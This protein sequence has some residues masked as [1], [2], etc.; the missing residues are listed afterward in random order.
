MLISGALVTVASDGSASYDPNGAFEALAVGDMTTDTFTYQIDDGN[1]GTD[2][3][4]VSVVINGVN[5][6][7]DAV[8]DDFGVAVDATLS[9]NVLDNNGNGED[10]DVDASD[11]LAVTQL[12]GSSAALGVATTITSGA[13]VTLNADG[14]FTYD[15]NGAFSGLGVGVTAT[16]TF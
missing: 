12:N 5:D 4:T 2:T 14:T 9:G 1:G 11:V 3:A 6:A 13:E 15:Q 16:D 10:M 8:N 7:P